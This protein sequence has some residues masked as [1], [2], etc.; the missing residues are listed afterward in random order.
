MKK[1]NYLRLCL[2]RFIFLCLV[3]ICFV[4]C[5][6][7]RDFLE[8]NQNKPS[9]MRIPFE[10]FKAN[11]R[12]YDKLATVKKD[13]SNEG[14]EHR[15]VYDEKYG[16]F[17]DPDNIL[18]ITKEN[19]K[20]YTIPMK[21]EEQDSL[22]K[23]LVLSEKLDGTYN[24]KIFGYKLNEQEV[25]YMRQGMQISNIENKT[26]VKEFI[27]SQNRFTD[28]NTV[29]DFWICGVQFVY[30]YF[31]PT[32]FEHE[33]GGECGGNHQGYYAWQAVYELCATEPTPIG[34][35]G[36][37]SGF[38]PIQP[39]GN[40][41]T[42]GS[43][44]NENDSGE[45]ITV[46]TLPG[47]YSEQGV[48]RPCES[49]RDMLINPDLKAK[50]IELQGYTG[51]YYEKG[52]AFKQNPTTNAYGIPEVIPE[53]NVLNILNMYPFV[54][55]TYVG[56]MHTHP[57]WLN[58]ESPI[59]MFGDGD[60]NYLFKV[61]NSYAPRPTT[62]AGYA[63]F[64]LTLTVASGTYCIKIKDYL[65]FSGV[66]NGG[67]WDELMKNLQENY[68][69]NATDSENLQLTLLRTL[70]KLGVGLYKANSTLSSWEELAIE[71]RP[72]LDDRVQGY[73]C[74]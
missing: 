63:K 1:K 36:A 33:P 61:A 12:A 35:V 13:K 4:N 73:P 20:Y 26:Y 67:K 72:Q 25:D 23:N 52:Y 42:G 64:F 57:R 30:T 48:N 68:R 16:A 38:Y 70:E 55:G 66:K 56:A 5:E 39:G 21:K 19:L 28:L 43:G 27:E 62:N 24:A 9:I 44:N 37:E 53:G 74:Q 58:D 71:R 34:D 8:E 47:I 3:S 40:T 15:Y 22:I 46:P 10:Q 50:L 69:Q 59:Q 41:N 31:P 65:K 54:G 49:L 32:C 60:L 2:F 29:M 6:S 17:I 51:L 14:I 7:E 18:L 45:V 11:G